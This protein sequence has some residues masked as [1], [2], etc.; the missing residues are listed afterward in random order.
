ME[1]GGGG[2]GGGGGRHTVIHTPAAFNLSAR[3]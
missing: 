3:A 2:G 1:L